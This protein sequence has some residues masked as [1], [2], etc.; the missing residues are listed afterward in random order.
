MRGYYHPYWL[1]SDELEHYGVKGMKWGKK[2]SPYQLAKTEFKDVKVGETLDWIKARN[3]YKT[4]TEPGGGW[5][6]PDTKKVNMKTVR[7]TIKSVGS[8][9]VSSIG[10]ST[11]SFGKKIVDYILKLFKKKK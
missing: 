9:S 6:D 4:A 11:L 2:K 10:G 5:W 3:V 1:Q 8:K 7:K